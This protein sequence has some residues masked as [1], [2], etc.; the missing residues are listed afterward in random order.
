MRNMFL[1]IGAGIVVALAGAVVVYSQQPEMIESQR[2]QN[3]PPTFIERPSR[4]AAKGQAAKDPPAVNA[5]KEFMRAKLTHSQKVLEGL[6]LEDFDLIAKNA[7]AMSLLSKD[8]TWQVLQTPQYL[9]QSQ[10]FQR[11]ADA[12]TD[13]AKKKSLDGAAL[14][15]VELTMKCINCH[16]YVRGV[17]SGRP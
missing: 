17:G 11:A 1:P 16:K 4:E 5:V 2:K 10:D 6:A 13:A 3:P 14:A 9:Q 15:Y 12:V 7:Q 8:A